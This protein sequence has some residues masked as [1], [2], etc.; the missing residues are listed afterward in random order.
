MCGIAGIF[1]GSGAG[2]EAVRRMI[3]L[4]EHRGPDG[5]GFFEAPGFAFGMRRLAVIDLVTGD[6]PM[7]NG[8]GTLHIVFNGEIYNHRELRAGLEAQGRV[9]RT[10][11]DTEVILQL[12]EEY[13]RAAVPR[14]HGMFAF[15]IYD[16]ARRKVF[17]A[18]DRFGEKPLFYSL[19]AGS[20]VFSSEITSLVSHQAVPRTISPDALAYYLHIGY[21]PAPL[22]FF[23][24]VRQL[25]PGHWLEFDGRDLTLERYFEPKAEVIE[26]W[27]E[28]EAAA[29]VRERLLTA[30]R[31][32]LISDVPLGAFLSGGIDSS[33]V[34]AAAQRVSSTP[35]R[36][37]TVKFEHAAY[38]ESPVAREVARFV[39]TD[40]HEIVVADRSFHADD[41][42]RIVR[43]VGQP[44]ADSS[45]IPTYLL[46]REV[47]KHITVALSGDGGD[48]MFA[49][50]PQ[51][52]W[53][54]LVDGI[55]RA[56]PGVGISLL[57]R[58]SRSGSN[59]FPRLNS[60]RR[61]TRAM[62]AAALPPDERIWRL[63]PLMDA[64]EL[65]AVLQDPLLPGENTFRI[66]RERV[67]SYRGTRLRQA[68]R[69]RLELS[70]PED[71]LVKV[72]RMSMAASLEVRAPF[73]DAELARFALTLPDHLLIRGRE[74]KYLLRRALEGW[75]PDVIWRQ[76]KRG[77]SI[78]LHTFLNDT[79]STMARDLLL[80]SGA[81]IQE[82]FK[83]A[84]LERLIE[85]ALGA[86]A[87]SASI[88]VY[89]A[90]HQ[91]W[92]IVQLAVWMQEFRPVFSG[93]AE[94]V[95]A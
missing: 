8:S 93:S 78:P 6:Q 76:P 12:F 19:S 79:Y 29:E 73:L 38:D 33:A 44:F 9:F 87:D 74:Q 77:F 89:R 39:G 22:T 94:G 55:A 17:I 91:L 7:S 70:L 5:V 65:R 56:L 85:R 16:S 50:Y 1:D 34:V 2:V 35:L 72:D 24:S 36:T 61:A 26:T 67:Q 27:S 11:S 90:T 47:R 4:L 54:G 28:S 57:E 68:M 20:L 62:Q 48:E 63:A 84:A 80:T 21:I 37:F 40:H 41:V 86:R 75:V 3:E 52:R 66:I 60:L 53:V 42:T 13:G 71:M 69:H 83:R 25:R 10:H 14:L 92:A 51:L 30:V 45:A 82:I 18:R 43:A 88:S 81:P 23:D 15:A 64:D 31:R 49:G 32:Q 46:S 58:A 59:L 95:A